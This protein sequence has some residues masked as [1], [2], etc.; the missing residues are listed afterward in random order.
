VLAARH[1]AYFAEFAEQAGRSMLRDLPDQ[2]MRRIEADFAD[3]TRAFE[4]SIAHDP[5]LAV[6]IYASLPFYFHST[7][8]THTARRWEELTRSIP[9]DQHLCARRS[10]AAGY[11][12]FGFRLLDEAREHWEA[13]LPGLRAAGD[14]LNE[15]WATMSLGAT[16]I[17]DPENHD[18]AVRMIERGIALA[19]QSGAPVLVGLG[20]NIVGELSRVHGDDDAA[21]AAYLAST[22]VA[23][24][25]GDHYREGVTTGNRVYIA[26][27]RGDYELALSQG[28]AAVDI[29]RRHGH[30]NQLPS[31]ALAVAGALVGLGRAEEACLLMGAA[32]EAIR[33]MMLEEPPG[34]VHENL[35]IRERVRAAAG[36]A[37]AE[38]HARGQAMPLDEAVGLF[39]D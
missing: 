5:P 35:A 8:L 17:G 32:D 26:T 24:T 10:I 13:A 20:F 33:R 27:H 23:R 18:E 2:G 1:A 9:A 34:D 25:I 19:D 29:H 4:W 38:W 3:I 11:V 16:H 31:V 14:R 39:D 22:Q 37:F 7:G 36:P 15:A 28:R 6:A 12:A 21:D 30:H